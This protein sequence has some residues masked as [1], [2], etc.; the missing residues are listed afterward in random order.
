MS[1]FIFKKFIDNSYTFFEYKLNL[2]TSIFVPHLRWQEH[3]L[4]L[5]RIFKDLNLSNTLIN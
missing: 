4:I 5:I 3:V 2:C 1:G